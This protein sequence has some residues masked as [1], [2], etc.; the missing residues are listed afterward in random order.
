MAL[1]P[2]PGRPCG[3][4]LCRAGRSIFYFH[5]HSYFLLTEK[6]GI[7][8][9]F[10]AT[11]KSPKPQKDF[12]LKERE[13]PSGF[14]LLRWSGRTMA[15]SG[16]RGLA[17]V[18]PATPEPRPWQ[19]ASHPGPLVTLPQACV[20]LGFPNTSLFFHKAKH[21]RETRLFKRALRRNATGDS[22]RGPHPGP[23]PIWGQM[24]VCL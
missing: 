12:F 9:V 24:S 1:P 22:T 21:R 11:S 23:D 16:G 4:N 7:R 19:S 17:P 13:G 10:F 8:A 2:E 15:E 5:S 3:P 14:C 6:L 18:P 20:C